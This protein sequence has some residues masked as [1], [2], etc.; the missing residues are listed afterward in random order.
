M[1]LRT[2]QN[3][4]TGDVVKIKGGEVGY[5]SIFGVVSDF[6]WCVVVIKW[7]DGVRGQQYQHSEMEHIEVHRKYNTKKKEKVNK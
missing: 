2:A 4:K 6:N 1:D 5:G 7:D 3:L